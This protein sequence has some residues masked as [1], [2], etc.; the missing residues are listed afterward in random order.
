[1]TVEELKNEKVLEEKLITAEKLFESSK[2]IKLSQ[3]ELVAFLN[4][5]KLHNANAD[6]IY[7]IYNQDEKFIGLGEIKENSLKREYVE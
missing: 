5:V 2:K 1:M 7:R 6:G 4:G 3:T